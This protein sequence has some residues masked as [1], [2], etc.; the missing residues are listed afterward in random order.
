MRAPPRASDWSLATRL[1]RWILVLTIVPVLGALLAGYV[2]LRQQLGRELTS[3][4]EEEL[5]ETVQRFRQSDSPQED[6]P[7]IAAELSAHHPSVRLAW[8]LFDSQGKTILG[9]YGERSILTNDSP[10]ATCTEKIQ[11]LGGGLMT[12]TIAAPK[13]LIVGVVLD[14]SGHVTLVT[15]YEIVALG[16]ALFSVVL[17]FAASRLLARK[18]TVLLDRVTASAGTPSEDFDP[19]IHLEGA[20]REIRHVAESLHRVLRAVRKESE[21]AR[22]F[23]MSLAHE[24]RSPVQ[25]LIG[26][27]EVALLRR[28][29]PHAYE[30][31]LASQLEELNDLANALDNLLAIFSTPAGSH[32]QAATDGHVETFD[33][34]AEARLRLAREEK[35]AEREGVLL[36]IDTEGNTEMAGNREAV[37]RGLCNVVANALNW[38]PRGADVGVA[39]DGSEDDIV[40]TVDD[41]G[42]GIPP[43]IRAD[44]F[45]PFFQGPQRRAGR[46]GYGLGLA[47]LEK[48]ITAQG[49]TVEISS[50]PAGGARFRITMRRKPAG[51][52]TAM[53][54][55]S[56]PEAET[57]ADRWPARRAQ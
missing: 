48:A 8:R 38:S 40:V 54:A 37:M 13:G 14:G 44:V 5:E 46:I 57:P 2:F 19:K 49:G 10:S 55:L 20:P 22:V 51:S 18:V 4:V 28:R 39:I 16:V 56:H 17:A 29:E 11:D 23:T 1:S 21:E 25:N 3:L 41:A 27:A 9:D 35:R 47:M 26:Q 53:A 33:L 43:E 52:K 32:G 30:A 50:S 45:R 36:V 24:L 7:Q 31:L 6:L 34:G 15:R 12:R 42:P